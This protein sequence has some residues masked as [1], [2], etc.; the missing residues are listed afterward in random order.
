MAKAPIKTHAALYR[1]PTLMLVC[2]FAICTL[3]AAAYGLNIYHKIQKGTELN[4][5]GRT[6]LAYVATKMRQSQAVAVEIPNP[7]TLVLV[8]DVDGQSYATSI[9]LKDGV[10]REYFGSHTPDSAVFNTP[11]TAA[12]EFSVAFLTEDLIEI[13]VGDHEGNLYQM[14]VYMPQ[15]MQEANL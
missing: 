11:I 13:T 4:F 1:I 10:L 3:L 7:F 8:E 15:A 14:S 5:T 6:G 9:F 12:S 2:L